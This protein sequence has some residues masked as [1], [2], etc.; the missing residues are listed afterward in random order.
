LIS[1]CYSYNFDVV[2]LTKSDLCAKLASLLD[3]YYCFYC[4]FSHI[5]QRTWF[6]LA[7]LN[8]V[9]NLNF[10]STLIFLLIHFNLNFYEIVIELY[11]LVFQHLLKNFLLHLNSPDQY[12]CI[13]HD[14]WF[15]FL[16][17]FHYF[18]HFYLI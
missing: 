6:V 18:R 16:E 2:D 15:L 11:Y 10:P 4:Y 12:F 7:S 9:L 3:Q 8:Y 14:V 13:S 1:D 5:S 17:W